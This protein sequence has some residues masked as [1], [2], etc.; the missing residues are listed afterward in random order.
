MS[1]VLVAYATKRGS[2]QDVAEAVAGT[3][4][5]HGLQVDVLPAGEVADVEGYDAVV[6]GGSLYMGRWHEDA[7]RLLKRQRRAL[8]ER[9]VAVFAL[10]PKT[11]AEAEVAGSREQLDRA[12]AAVPDVK[13]VSVAVFGGV[14]DPAKFRFPL[15]RLPASDARDWDAIRE[16][17]AGFAMLAEQMVK[18]TA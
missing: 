17:A 3:L 5:H 7:R 15:D 8:A 12:L 18:M 1:K 13:P 4:Q 10:G 9:P 2:T 6:L 14:I 11:L 16:W